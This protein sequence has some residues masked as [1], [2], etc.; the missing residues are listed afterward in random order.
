MSA[1][2]KTEAGRLSETPTGMAVIDVGASAIR[3]TVAEIQAGGGIRV[4][5]HLQKAVS[6]GRDVFSAGVISQDTIRQCVN[7]LAGFLR[8]CSEYGI[9]DPTHVRAVATSAVREA[10]NRDTFLDRIYIATG[11]SVRVIDEAEESR[12]MFVA[13]Q[14]VLSAMPDLRTGPTLVADVGP[15]HS[16]VL[17]I[18]NGHVTF[19]NFYRMG[20][21][22]M[23]QALEMHRTPTARVATILGQQIERVVEQMVKSV[24]VSAVAA[25]VVT[26]GEAQI[27]AQRLVPDSHEAPYWKVPY[28]NLQAFLEKILTVPTE[29]LVSQ[30]QIPYPEAETIG[31]AL[32]AVAHMARAFRTDT[33]LVVRTALRD[34]L[35][36]ETAARGYW[37]PAFAEEVVA[38]A[39]SLAAKYHADPRHARHVADLAIAL[40][41]ALRSEHRLTERHRVLLEAAALLH[42]IGGY[43]SS[44]SHHKHSM[45]LIMNSDLFGLTH[46]DLTLVAVTARYHRRAIPK[47]THEE[48][49]VL[50]R[51]DR[52]AVAKMAAL[53]RLADA[54]DRHHAQRV[55]DVT[56]EREE[57]R[58][59]IIVPGVEDLTVERL[60][61]KEKGDLF[62]QVFGRTVELREV[63]G[64]SEGEKP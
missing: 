25:L 7:V 36:R 42:E 34:G 37:T 24:P 20:S 11:L 64:A 27:A 1:M 44:R 31:P 35:L 2:I 51:D 19:S 28:K 4:V 12:L 22:R 33:L 5:E 38:S 48:Y 54:L 15:G 59:I 29:R 56:I 40:F 9:Q 10:E 17:L 32:L 8:V 46:E 58:L 3:M 52:I 57:D 41:D 30:H 45:Y 49:M 13:L 39:Q 47:P 18:E 62:E 43:V 55:R 14:D 21:L 26:S 60:A 23:R 61:V 50:S 53:L 63:R 16:E 6:L